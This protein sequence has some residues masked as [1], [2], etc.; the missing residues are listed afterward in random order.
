MAGH[1][2]PSFASSLAARIYIIR[3]ARQ[4]NA[5][6]G[7]PEFSDTKN[8]GRILSA[9]VGFRLVNKRDQFGVCIRGSGIYSDDLFLIFR[10]TE[11]GFDWVTDFRFGV[12]VS[13][14]GSMVHAGF[15]QTFNSMLN[16]L[17]S[18]IS[19]Q[20][21][22]KTIHCIGHSLG[23]AVANL[24]AAWA[25]KTYSKKIKLYTFGAPRVGF[26]SVGFTTSLTTNI[27]ADN[28]YRVYHDSDPVPML[29][30]FPYFHAPTKGHAYNIPYGGTVV[31][32]AHEISSYT[33]SIGGRE[34]WTSLFRPEP[35]MS[36]SSV[37]QW[38]KSDRP[39]SINNRSTWEKLNGAIGFVAHAI[40]A[41]VA[42]GFAAG[43]TVADYL[44]MILR[45]GI[46]LVTDTAEWVYLL[47]RKMMKILGMKVVETM[48]ELT[49]QLLRL[50]LN[51]IAKRIYAEAKKAINRIIS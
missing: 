9:E 45:K 42:F 51:R 26:G 23:G 12:N 22:I 31:F 15:N 25:S 16:D 41:K 27:G 46:E 36:A 18:F 50:V 3:D 11:G 34:E 19:Q 5:L 28:I 48:E 47:V 40:L 35:K 10:G 37:K 24:A 17:A 29:P 6:R 13:A 21:G 43:L 30:L 38:L 20:K 14:T 4:L 7:L 32:A 39:E 8:N 44:A 33:G 1:L 2:T 49:M